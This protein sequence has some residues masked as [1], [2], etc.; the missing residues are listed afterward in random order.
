[1][2]LA[3]SQKKTVSE[4]VTEGKSIAEIQRLI[5][6]DFSTSMTYMEVRFLIDDLD[7][8]FKEAEEDKPE[9][10]DDEPEVVEATLHRVDVDIDAVTPPGALMSGRAT[11]SDG[12]TLDWQ[13]MSNG[14][15]GADSWRKC[16]T[17]VQAR[18]TCRI[19]APRWMR[20]YAK[21]DSLP[22]TLLCYRAR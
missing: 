7:V 5:Q 16:K 15:A 14:R 19:F 20:F 1:M 13:L 2:S 6:E 3:E 21:K 22:N 10:A 18:R 9:K 4:W 12:V 8:A 17:I 11:F